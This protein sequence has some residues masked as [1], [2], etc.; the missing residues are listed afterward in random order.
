MTKEAEIIRLFK[1]TSTLAYTFS[2]NGNVIYR[3][4]SLINSINE[5]IMNA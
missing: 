2:T 1:D 4:S 5:Y 3:N